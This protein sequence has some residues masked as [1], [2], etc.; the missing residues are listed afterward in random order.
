M[1]DYKLPRYCFLR[2][3]D[4]LIIN[5]KYIFEKL[6]VAHCS[7]YLWLF[8]SPSLVFCSLLVINFWKCY[9]VDTTAK[10]VGDAP[11]IQTEGWR[12]CPYHGCA[13]Y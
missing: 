13:G 6:N 5:I 4:I 7:G 12:Y 9:C 8:I 11:Q 10:S 2:K 3:L 1:P